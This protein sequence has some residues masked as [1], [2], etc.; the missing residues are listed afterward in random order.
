MNQHYNI[1][2]CFTDF[3]NEKPRK[4]DEKVSSIESHP[5]KGSYNERVS[6]ARSV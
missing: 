3:M 5:S 4:R 1:L 2:T 6:A